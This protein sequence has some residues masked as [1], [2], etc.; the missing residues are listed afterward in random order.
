M[1]STTATATATCAVLYCQVS[2][3]RGARGLCCCRRHTQLH[4]WRANL[5]QKLVQA[6]NDAIDYVTH[7]SPWN[8]HTSWILCFCGTWRFIIGFKEARHWSWPWANW[9]HSTTSSY[10]TFQSF[11]FNNI[12]LL[13]HRSTKRWFSGKV[14]Y[15]CPISPMHATCPANF[16]FLA[17]ITV[18]WLRDQ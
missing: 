11:H 6:A 14:F 4:Q 17:L 16:I 12:F 3:A 9:M 15:V 7:S 18:T 1:A 2:F 13:K 8:V 5:S 10:Y